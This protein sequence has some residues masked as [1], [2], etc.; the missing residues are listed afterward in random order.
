[1]CY[2]SAIFTMTSQSTSIQR[3]V[4]ETSIVVCSYGYQSGRG[5]GATGVCYRSPVLNNTVTLAFANTAGTV[6]CV[7]AI[8]VSILSTEQ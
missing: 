7:T 6:L 8:F 4:L 5:I 3:Y 1:M 2:K